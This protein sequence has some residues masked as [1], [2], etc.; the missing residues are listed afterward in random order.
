M[1]ILWLCLA[2]AIFYIMVGIIF[3]SWCKEFVMS[4][5]VKQPPSMLMVLPI[6]I[7]NIVFWPVVVVVLYIEITRQK[8][9]AQLPSVQVITR[10][11][12]K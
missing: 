10:S 1:T 5:F 9:Q 12:D 6:Y 2:G 7:F 4:A 8:K 3:H 11:Y